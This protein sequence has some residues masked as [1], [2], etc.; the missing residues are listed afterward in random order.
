MLDKAYVSE[1]LV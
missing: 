1:S